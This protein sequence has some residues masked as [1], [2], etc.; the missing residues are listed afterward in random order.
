MENLPRRTLDGILRR[1]PCARRWGR[2]PAR[3]DWR[4]A[5]VVAARAFGRLAIG[6]PWSGMLS[7]SSCVALFGC[8]SQKKLCARFHAL[9]PRAI[10]EF[11]RRYKWIQ[12]TPCRARV[13][14]TRI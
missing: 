14:A 12:G 6:L 2:G 5:M 13:R 7:D 8:A 9:N 4:G 10:F 1:V 11:D 3:D